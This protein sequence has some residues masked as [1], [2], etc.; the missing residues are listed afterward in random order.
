[1]T[2]YACKIRITFFIFQENNGKNAKMGVT[3]IL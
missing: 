1:M 2:L 3:I